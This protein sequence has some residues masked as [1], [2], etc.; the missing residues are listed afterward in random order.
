MELQDIKA[1]GAPFVVI[2]PAAEIGKQHCN[3]IIY[4]DR[5]KVPAKYYERLGLKKPE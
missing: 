2:E 4:K 1:H 3:F 5:S